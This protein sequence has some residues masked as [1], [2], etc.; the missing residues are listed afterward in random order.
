MRMT[1]N[2]N[3][4]VAA[5]A[6]RIISRQGVVKSSRTNQSLFAKVYRRDHCRYLNCAVGK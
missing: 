6:A 1:S 3:L 4:M 2:N 5:C